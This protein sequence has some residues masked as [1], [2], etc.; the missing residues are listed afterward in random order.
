MRMNRIGF[1]IKSPQREGTGV[2]GVLWSETIRGVNVG[3]RRLPPYQR[4][5][6]RCVAR[7][8]EIMVPASRFELLTPRV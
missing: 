8:W 7:L 2:Y 6:R 4:N 1:N 3:A 5:G